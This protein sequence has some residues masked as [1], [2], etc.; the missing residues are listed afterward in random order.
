MVKMNFQIIS[1]FTEVTGK[2]N[3]SFCLNQVIL[4]SVEISEVQPCGRI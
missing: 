3:V 1:S 4:L 2:M